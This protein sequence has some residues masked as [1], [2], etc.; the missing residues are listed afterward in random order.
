MARSPPLPLQKNI[1]A[2]VRGV[3]QGGAEVAR[4]RVNQATG[5]I[6]IETTLS[7]ALPPEPAEGEWDEFARAAAEKMRKI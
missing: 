2:A 4:I 6:L 3:R 7:P 1:A 5:D